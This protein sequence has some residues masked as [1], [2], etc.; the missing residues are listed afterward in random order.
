MNVQKWSPKLVVVVGRC[1]YS[2]EVVNSGLTAFK[3]VLYSPII[4]HDNILR[5]KC[6][7]LY[8]HM[9]GLRRKFVVKKLNFGMPP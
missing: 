5:N 7:R 6:I 1:Y 9:S 4:S 3:R 8:E 2:E